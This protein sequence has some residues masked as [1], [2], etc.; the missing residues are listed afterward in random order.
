[1]LPLHRAQVAESLASVALVAVLASCGDAGSPAVA[2][3]AGTPTADAS[4]AP[5]AAS[6]AD[7]SGRGDAGAPQCA[8]YHVELRYLLADTP[9]LPFPLNS[10]R[11]TTHFLSVYP[12]AV[13]ADERVYFFADYDMAGRTIAEQFDLFAY[14]L[15]RRGCSLS[16]VDELR[17]DELVREPVFDLTSG[18]SVPIVQAPYG[19]AGQL[20]TD[21]GINVWDI[22]DVALRDTDC[23]GT[24][25]PSVHYEGTGAVSLVWRYA[26]FGA[27]VRAFRIY[28]GRRVCDRA[29]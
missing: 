8:A 10:V 13:S 17:R 12:R 22:T 11:G 21:S 1:M 27:Q 23:A 20:P 26:G 14:P 5:D 16:A 4:V 2:P 15:D 18:S 6:A 9:P 29:P 25:R 24:V 3:G 19:G 28:V 7:A